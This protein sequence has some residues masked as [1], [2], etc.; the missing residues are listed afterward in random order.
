MGH[1]SRLARKG[2]GLL[3]VLFFVAMLS[4]CGFCRY[5]KPQSCPGEGCYSHSATEEE[6]TQWNCPNGGVICNPGGSCP[7]GRSCKTKVTGGYCSCSC[8]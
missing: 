2:I 4:G 8:S 1:I 7:P 3:F 6:Q 5:C